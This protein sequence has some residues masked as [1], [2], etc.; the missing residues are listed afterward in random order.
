MSARKIIRCASASL[1]ILLMLWTVSL[2]AETVS[3]SYDDAGRLIGAH[4]ESG[5]TISYVFDT[6]GN[7]LRETITQFIDSDGDGMDDGW[8]ITQFGNLS[9]NGADDFDH[10]GQTDL[11]EYMA[12]TNPKDNQSI[13][14]IVQI[15]ST[16]KVAFAIHW[17]S[18]SGKYYRVQYNDTLSPLGWK[19]LGGDVL[20]GGASAS[21]TDDNVPATAHRFYRVVALF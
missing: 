11:Q 10:D 14:K 1:S 21:K 17:T 4:Y 19:N 3:Y 7:L 8:E 5:Q 18:L 6:G 15:D 12:G 9:R 16:P 2:G 13:L 20:A